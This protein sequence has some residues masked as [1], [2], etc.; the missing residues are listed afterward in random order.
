[1]DTSLIVLLVGI[2]AIVA[3]SLQPKDM[4]PLL[5]DLGLVVLGTMALLW[6]MEHPA[7]VAEL[8]EQATNS[9]LAILIVLA[10]QPLVFLAARW[11]AKRLPAKPHGASEAE[12][13]TELVIAPARRGRF[14]KEPEEK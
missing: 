8:K 6:A 4:V 9:G 5:I 14:W 13:K 7:R 2:A 3:V 11:L 12:V 1:M 10:C